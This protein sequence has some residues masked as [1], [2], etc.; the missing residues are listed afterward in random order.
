VHDYGY[1]AS[2]SYG[3]NLSFV[4][5]RCG[6]AIACGQTLSNAVNAVGQAVPY[7]FSGTAGEAV[8]FTARTSSGSLDAYADLYGPTGN[9][10]GRAWGGN[11]GSVSLP[12]TGT[13]TILVHDYGYT[14][15]GS[16][17]LNL[18][19]VT[20][21]CGTAI[22][23]GQ[24]LSNAVNAVGQAVPYLSAGRRERR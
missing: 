22:A 1:T 7:T 24:T 23:C 3:L 11:S 12:A 21:R 14:A 16:Y 10:L 5:G 4:T 17:G 18:S 2:G 19:F 8:V 13:Y 15:S 9:N 6:T 20:G